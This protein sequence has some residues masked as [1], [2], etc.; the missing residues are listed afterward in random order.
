ML[1]PAAPASPETL[2]TPTSLT[3]C[4][5]PHACRA[6]NRVGNDIGTQY[7]HGI[8]PHS[9]EQEKEAAAAIERAQAKATRKVVTEVVRASVFWPAE[10]YHR[11]P[12]RASKLQE[13]RPS[14]PLAQ[15]PRIHLCRLHTTRCWRPR[16]PRLRGATPRRAHG[17]DAHPAAKRRT[18]RQS[19]ARRSAHRAD[20]RRVWQSA[21]CKRAASRP[22]RRPPRPSAATASARESQRDR[23]S[24]G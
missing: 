15:S 11:E 18:R 19:P 24:G 7:R 14:Q 8:Y 22:R 9:A 2:D 6:L 13:R 5:G 1:P 4:R 20:P 16:L 17:A 23:A 21:T 3:S 10:K 12:P